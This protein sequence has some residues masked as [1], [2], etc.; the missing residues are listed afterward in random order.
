MSESQQTKHSIDDQEDSFSSKEAPLES[1]TETESHIDTSKLEEDPA[2]KAASLKILR[3]ASDVYPDVMGGLSLHVH[4]MSRLQAEWGHDVTVLTSDHGD[5]NLPSKEERS[6][7]ELIRHREIASP[8]DNTIIPG[9]VQTIR[10]MADDY[11]VIHAHSH[12]FFSTNATAA[13]SRTLDTPLVITNHGLISQTAP[14]WLQ[15]AFIPTVAKFTLNAADEVLCYTETDKCRLRE[16]GIDSSISII[17]NGIDCDR[18]SPEQ[19]DESKKQILF[20]GRLKPGKGV[21][22]LLTAFE[23]LTADFPEYSLKIVGNGPLLDDLVEMAHECNIS[24]HIEFAGQIE[25]NEIG[26]V[27]AESEVFV[28]PSLNEG[29]PRTVLEAMACEVPVVTSDLDQ[30]IPIVNNAGFTV[31]SE[32]PDKF[33]AAIKKLLNDAELQNEMG[34]VGR[35]RVKNHYSWNNTVSETLGIYKS[36]L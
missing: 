30:L 19:S 29:V 21:Q 12:L 6:G 20:V 3:V 17:N 14:R 10:R 32:S 22:T 28:L 34:R 15:K 8:L 16:R 25:N 7:Y 1:K 35:S 11:D 23:Q 27:Y 9:I 36:L 18:F 33:Q 13:L 31:P 26:E 24:T 4:E 5:R 2:N